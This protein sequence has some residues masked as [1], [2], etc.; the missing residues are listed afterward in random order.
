MGRGWPLRNFPSAGLYSLADEIADGSPKGDIYVTRLTLFGLPDS[1][2]RL[3]S[4]AQATGHA[5]RRSPRIALAY[6]GSDGSDNVLPLLLPE[7]RP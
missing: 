7:S 1:H 2:T 4:K 6:T 3:Q 5:A